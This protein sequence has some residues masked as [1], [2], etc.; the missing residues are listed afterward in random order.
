MRPIRRP[1]SACVGNI[2]LQLGTNPELISRDLLNTL[3][4]LHVSCI[5]SFLLFIIGNNLCF[6][7]IHSTLFNMI[8]PTSPKVIQSLYYC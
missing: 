4:Y 7:H 2:E 8:R 6:M 3:A 5:A 1:R